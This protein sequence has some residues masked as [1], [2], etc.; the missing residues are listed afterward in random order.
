MGNNTV[1]DFRQNDF[2]LNHIRHTL[3]FYDPRVVDEQGGFFQ[4]FKDNGEIFD[5]DTRTLVASCRFVFNYAQAYRHF[6]QPQYLANVHHGLAFLRNRHRRAQDGAYL[7]KLSGEQVLDDTNHCYGLAFVMLAYATSLM[8]GVQEA[9]AWVGETFDLM[10]SR[11]WEPEFG[12]YANQADAHWVLDPYR[13]QN[14]NMHACEALMMAFEATGEARYL[15]RAALLAQKFAN[16]ALPSAHLTGE[17]IW[18][19]YHRDWTPDLDYNKNDDGNHLRPWG[20]QTGHQTE[21][22]KLLLILDRHAPAPWHLPRAKQLFDTAMR[23]GWDEENGG[24]IYGYD[25]EGRAVFRDKYF[26]VQAESIA[27]AALL[28]AR[29]QDA[30]YWA[31]YDKLWRYSWEVFVDHEFGGWY[32]VLSPQNQR[33]SDKKTWSNKADYHTMG[34]CYEVLKSKEIAR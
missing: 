32:R 10:A 8:A 16:F 1:P 31:W 28:A 13:G 33:Y 34:A 20:V 6:A 9:R 3:S 12:V 4:C 25:L 5:R 18:E 17:H 2:L 22:A 11:F 27:A 7:W 29:T 19:H 23:Y 26:W 24:L 21:W 14:D 15:E 30:S